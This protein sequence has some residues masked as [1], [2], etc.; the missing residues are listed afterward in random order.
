MPDNTCSG[1]CVADRIAEYCEA[2]LITSG[3]C[4]TGSKCCVSRDIYPDNK[5]PVD[6]RIPNAHSQNN[7]T[8]AP[9]KPTKVNLKYSFSTA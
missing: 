9:S 3:L 1:V 4:K 7:R 2:Y 6:L 5:Y 8:N